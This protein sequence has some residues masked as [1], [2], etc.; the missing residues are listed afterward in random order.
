M[1]HLLTMTY[2]CESYII[3]VFKNYDERGEQK[4]NVI[5]RMLILT[6]NVLQVPADLAMEKLTDNE[7]SIHDQASYNVVESLEILNYK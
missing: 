6:R 7:P 1:L 4:N 3:F 5:E 2:Y